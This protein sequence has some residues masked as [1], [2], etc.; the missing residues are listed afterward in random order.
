MIQGQCL[1]QYLQGLVFA[2]FK[3]AVMLICGK[4]RLVLGPVWATRRLLLRGEAGASREVLA[5]PCLGGGSLTA[6]LTAC[7][8]AQELLSSCSVL[9]EQVSKSLGP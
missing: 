6:A 9:I 3:N 5:L 8:P 2:C 1:K 7:L 4:D